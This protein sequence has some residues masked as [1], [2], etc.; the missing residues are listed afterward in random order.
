MQA[1]A[2]KTDSKSRASAACAFEAGILIEDWLKRAD[3]K[4]TASAVS[5]ADLLIEAWLGQV[6]FLNPFCWIELQHGIALSQN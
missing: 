1:Q 5:E 3:S 4:N 2:T 6:C